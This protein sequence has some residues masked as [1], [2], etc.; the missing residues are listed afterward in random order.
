MRA[1]DWSA[2]NC[3]PQQRHIFRSA[4]IAEVTDASCARIRSLSK[5]CDCNLSFYISRSGAAAGSGVAGAKLPKTVICLYCERRSGCFG[6]SMKYLIYQH[7]D[8]DSLPV[9]HLYNQS[10]SM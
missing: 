8:S 7:K 9:V 4:S 6:G 2:T 1:A 5:R 3:K 10:C